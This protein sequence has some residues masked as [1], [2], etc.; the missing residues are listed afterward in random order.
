MFST[1]AWTQN[2]SKQDSV[3]INEQVTSNQRLGCE[4]GDG[5]VQFWDKGGEV[6]VWK[7]GW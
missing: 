7:H 6:E 5:S 1:P 4:N 2:V 3:S